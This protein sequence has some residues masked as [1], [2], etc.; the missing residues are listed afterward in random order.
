[1]S[2]TLIDVG[3]AGEGNE[4]EGVRTAEIEGT[5]EPVGADGVGRGVG[6][7]ILEKF[8]IAWDDP[9]RW[10]TAGTPPYRKVVSRFSIM[11]PVPQITVIINLMK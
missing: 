8:G 11:G 1:M 6:S 4:A 5:V 9:V 2:A 7:W 10:G 3:G